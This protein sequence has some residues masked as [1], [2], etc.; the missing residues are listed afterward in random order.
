MPLVS[1]IEPAA[2]GSAPAVRLRSKNGQLFFWSDEAELVPVRSWRE[3]F[4]R[5][6]SVEAQ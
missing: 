4:D 2:R 5:L 1:D 3:Y 6:G